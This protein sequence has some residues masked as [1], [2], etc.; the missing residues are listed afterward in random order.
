MQ[1]KTD[2]KKTRRKPRYVT[3]NRVFLYKPEHPNTNVYGYV[4]EHVLVMTDHLKRAM[5][6]GELIH[7][8]NGDPMD[9]RPEN[10]VV[11]TR[12]AH[13]RLHPKR[14]KPRRNLVCTWCRKHF[15]RPP[16]QAE[17]KHIFCSLR[18]KGAFERAQN[19]HDCDFCAKRFHAHTK[20]DRPNRHRFCS[21]RCWK[22]A[23]A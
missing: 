19:M 21:R 2:N 22:A 5:R 1:T 10:L 13:A 11:V 14:K 12:A 9:N 15:E 4:R 8:I 23:I 6:T 7:H 20:K 18:C 17:Y 16:W 3:G